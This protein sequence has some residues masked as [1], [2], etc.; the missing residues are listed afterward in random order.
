MI[1][2]NNAVKRLAHTVHTSWLV[3]NLFP[4]CN[5]RLV[6]WIPGKKEK[7]SL[8][9]QFR[10]WRS[11]RRYWSKNRSFWSRRFNRRYKWPGSMGPRIREIMWKVPIGRAQVGSRG[12]CLWCSECGLGQLPYRLYGER[13]DYNSSWHKP[14]GLYPPWSFSVRPLR[15]TPPRQKYFFIPWSLLP[16]TWRKPTRT[17]EYVGRGR[18]GP[19]TEESSLVLYFES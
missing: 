14:M 16:A 15:M 13:K 10:N 12:F 5:M 17:C 19:S 8:K 9:R 1:S 3:D 2:P 4:S 11:R 7:G 6:C 18:G